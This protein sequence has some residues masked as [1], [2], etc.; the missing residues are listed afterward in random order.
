MIQI[1]NKMC[2]YENNETKIYGQYQRIK[3][4][5]ITIEKI[6]PESTN[7]EQIP[8]QLVFCD[9]RDDFFIKFYGK[10]DQINIHLHYN[11]GTRSAKF[12]LTY[13]F[14]NCNINLERNK[15]AIISTICKDYSHRLEEWIKY[16]LKL[17]FTGIVIFNNSGNKANG[18]NEPLENCATNIPMEEI[19]NKYKDRVILIDCP[20]SP[21]PNNHWNNIQ[22]ITLHIGINAFMN[23][24]K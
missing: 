3:P 22:R 13:P 2:I 6:P 4:N 23:K 17:G 24:C 11:K 15:S 10:L 5:N 19:C 21:F 16:N 20:Y 9:N 18:L 14:E 1:F 12:T 7:I 8:C